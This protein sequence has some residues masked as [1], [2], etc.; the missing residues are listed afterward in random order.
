MSKKR[1][2]NK[3]LTRSKKAG[4]PPGALVYVG[5]HREEAVS[6][7]MLDFNKAEVNETPLAKIENCFP[8]RDTPTNTWINING[9][10]NVEVIEKLGR[11]FQWH[12]LVLEDLLNATQRPKLDDYTAYMLAIVKMIYYANGRLVIEQVSLILSSQHVLSFQEIEGD[13]FQPVRHRINHPQ[14]RLRNLGNDYLFYALLDALVDNYF[15]V[16]EE[17]GQKLEHLEEELLD[18]RDEEVLIELQQYRKELL[19]IRRSVYPLREVVGRLEKSESTL[20]QSETGKYLRDLYDHTIQII[21]TT[22]TFREM[23][24]TLM[25]SH[26]SAISNRMNN[27]MKVLTIIATIFIPLTFIAGIYGMNFDHMPELHWKYGY[28]TV[29]G[30]MVV[31]FVAMMIFFRRKKWI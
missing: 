31:I 29:W 14:S 16:L 25:D 15:I 27:V 7:S 8:F 2:K 26:M 10:H 21:E 5:A 19:R 11:H 6:F 18:D 3:V 9:I 23:I 13:V 22:E 1:R 24:S 12:P 20:I 28:Y 4:M 17:F 30:V